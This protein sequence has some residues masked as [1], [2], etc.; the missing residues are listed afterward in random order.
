[1][2]AFLSRRTFLKTMGLAGAV[3]RI[4]LPPLAAMFNSNG[5]A[6]AGGVKTL[7][8]RFVLWFNGNGIPEKY[9]IPRKTG[10]G[11][12]IT[13]CLSPLAPF[14]DDIHVFTGLDSPAARVPQPGNSH[15]PSMSAL[16]SGQ[17]FTGRGAGGRSIDQ[18]IARKIGEETRFR[19][20]QIGVSQESF[21][22]SIQRNLSW[23]DRD[24]PLPP[25]MLPHQLFDRLFGVNEPSW[26]KRRKSILDSVQQEARA[27]RSQLE[28]D[29]QAR[30]DEYLGSVRELEKSIAS[31]PPEYRTVVERPAEGGDLR[32]WPRIAKL[33]SDLLV[34][35]LASGQTLV[36][37]YMLTKC[38]G[39]SR[40]PWLGLTAQRHHEYT[41][42]QVETPRG[43]RILRD[44]CRWH[45]EEFA[46]LVGRLKATPEGDGSLLDNTCLLFV[47]EHAEANPHK[48][49][50]LAVIV[51]GH[52]SSL[53]TGLHT[54]TTGTLG[55]LY[56]TLAEEVVGA[57]V[58]SFPTAGRKLAEV[59]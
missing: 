22:E 51:A 34:H 2:A 58:G 10:A 30:L 28:N 33:Q 50:N 56:L 43:M 49:N 44:I 12:E 32:D 24:R 17:P 54:R 47:H 25:E 8:K 11:F 9:W 38:Q 21:G 4:G 52:A 23:A 39:L 19:S 37:S 27:L 3:V 59:V 45:V 18:V 55:D 36:A 7:P 46:Y 40:F 15:Y 57:R 14:R 41:H 42:G 6:Y 16:V 53:K 35:A 26:V 1:M 31:L 5:T 48:N 13:P 29:D 20:L